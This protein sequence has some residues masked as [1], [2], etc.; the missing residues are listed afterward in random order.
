[1]NS[2]RVSPGQRFRRNSPCPVC[3]GHDQSPK[4]SRCWGYVSRDGL[5]VHCTRAD[6][7]ADLPLGPDGA[8]A[9]FLPGPCKC[10]GDHDP[11]VCPPPP[12]EDT[13]T[14]RA[15]R[16]DWLNRL[17]TESGPITSGDP[18]DLY[19]RSRGIKIDFDSYPDDLKFH[20]SLTY[21]GGGGRSRNYPAMLAVIRNTD[22][23]PVGFHRTYLT[24]FGEKSPVSSPK[25]MTPLIGAA[26]SIQLY[27]PGSRLAVAEGIETALSFQ[28]LSGIP[29]WSC[30]SSIGIER[31][32]PPSGIE[33]I[34]VAGDYD[35]AGVRAAENLIRR[36]T[37][38]KIKAQAIFPDEPG[39]DW[40]DELR[41]AING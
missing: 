10:G 4:G 13:P 11:G 25:K 1:M 9:H 6:S 17:A 26:N 34:I 12:E 38:Q 15:R 31:F 3:G 27:V 29:T 22:G 5:Y 19:L 32:T 16:I 41:E 33:E 14:R 8:Y 20:P 7:A 28:I 40:N 39:T 35:P 36:L 2:Q 21:V 18:V 24:L 30:L 37:R 23:R